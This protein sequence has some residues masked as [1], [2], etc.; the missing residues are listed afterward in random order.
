MIGYDELDIYAVL[1]CLLGCATPDGEP[2]PA[3]HGYR[4][5]DLCTDRLRDALA[6]VVE[7]YAVLDDA[8]V[9]GR[10]GAN[11]GRGAP[12]YGSR[13]PARD[14]VIA[15]T[16]PRTHAVEEGDP[17]SVL[18]IL[19]S[20][21]DNVRDDTGQD[22][23]T[24]PST[25]FGEVSFLVRW[26]DFITRQYWVGDFGDEV[27]E[28]AHQLRIALGLQE[29]SI[30]VGVCPTSI[31][32]L[33]HGGRVPCGALLRARLTAE[34]IT[35]RRCGAA[36]SRDR[37]DELGDELGT[38]VSDVASLSVWLNKP[39]GTLR[40]WKHEDGWHNHGTRSRPLFARADVLASWR[41][42]RAPAHP[43]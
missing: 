42:R 28:L 13:S 32:D 15:L 11:G 26:M 5:C 22:P 29:R 33:D 37:W 38:P 1:P 25:V 34:R 43:V 4:T 6:E 10:A 35:C 12:G 8:L 21:A 30:P 9:P 39:P 40:R 3:R 24:G 36:W 7:C 23:R 27:H 31:L 14:G 16:D 20:W 18:A 17:H 2:F 19:E 41:R